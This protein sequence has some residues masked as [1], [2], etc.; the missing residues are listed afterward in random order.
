MI[1]EWGEKCIEDVCL[2]VWGICKNDG[3]KFIVMMDSWGCSIRS[4]AGGYYGYI[5]LAACDYHNPLFTF[6]L[7]TG[8]E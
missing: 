3:G 2:C 1:K 7:K 8:T 4:G 6:K 5:G